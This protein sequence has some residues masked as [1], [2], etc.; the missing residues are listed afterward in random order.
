MR[1]G[2]FVIPGEK[3][4]VIEEFV[5][6]DNVY[7]DGKGILRSETFGI[8]KVFKN[9]VDVNPVRSLEAPPKKGEVVLAEVWVSETA[10]FIAKIV[11]KWQPFILLTNTISGWIMKDEEENRLIRV[12]DL[13]LAKVESALYNQIMLTIAGDKS[14]G[15]VYAKCLKC[16]VPLKKLGNTL[17]CPICESIHLDRKI[18]PFYGV[19][20]F[21]KEA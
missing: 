2:M 11:A 8:L 15:V 7:V 9:K 17:V 14:L 5:P 10:R 3:L 6:G 4:G 13:I 16:S 1:E 20:P 12:G 18:S 19:N 21:S